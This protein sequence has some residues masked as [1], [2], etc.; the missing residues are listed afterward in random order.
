MSEQ[1]YSPMIE[2]YLQIKEQNKDSILFFRLGDFYEMFFEDAN[3]ASRELELTLTGKECGMPER[4]PMCG[5]P[6]HSAETYIAR[7]I[8]KGYKVAICEQT[9]DAG[10]GKKL[11]HRD[12]VRVVTPGTVIEN[13]MLDENSNNYICSIYI[14][15]TS[16]AVCFIDI[17]TGSASSCELSGSDVKDQIISEIVKFSPSE[18]IVNFDFSLDAFSC[19]YMKKNLR[20]NVECGYDEGFS[21]ENARDAICAHFRVSEPSA[22]GFAENSP[23]VN[24]AGALLAYIHQTQKTNL[25]HINKMEF[26]SR[27]EYMLLDPSV[28]RNLEICET[29]RSKEKRGSLLWAIDKTKCKMTR[30]TL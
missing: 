18:A 21:L 7:L 5:V 22:V 16:A 10:K 3:I 9:E 17:S 19:D 14:A 20:I 15:G 25:S 23:T 30:K 13:T 1:K 4:A 11:V 27:E 6:Y 29:M 24:A 12:I 28:R 2:Q 26:Y 8:A